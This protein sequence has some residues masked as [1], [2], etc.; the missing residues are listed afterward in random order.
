MHQPA[1]TVTPE[2]LRSILEVRAEEE[3]A[4]RLALWLEISG[5]NGSEYSYDLYFASPADSGPGDSVFEVDGLTVVVPA[6]SVGNLAGSTLDVRD[7][8]MILINPNRPPQPVGPDLPED[9]EMASPV[10]MAVLRVLEEEIN[11]A[12]AAHG[13]MAEL[14][15]V[16]GGVAYLR[17]GGGCQGCG[18]ATVTLSQGI[19]V[20]I[21]EAVPEIHTVADVTDHASGSNPYFEGAK[22]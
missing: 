13:G 11:P 6:A 19:E 18:M 12:I 1:L 4:D 14:V 21:R 7:G 10:A 8:G 2:A 15:G 5:V 16:A 3:D 17:L 22:K 9:L 20:A